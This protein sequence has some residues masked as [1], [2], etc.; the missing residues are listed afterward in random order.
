MSGFLNT[1]SENGL[2]QQC[3]KTS[4]ILDGDF[5]VTCLASTLNFPQNGFTLINVVGKVSLTLELG[6]GALSDY[7]CD[8]GKKS[9][10]TAFQKRFY[11]EFQSFWMPNQGLECPKDGGTWN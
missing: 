1:K 8:L 6:L 4:L 10:Q 11:F 5:Q 3:H 9:L 7:F 2:K